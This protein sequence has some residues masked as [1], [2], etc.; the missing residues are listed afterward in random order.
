[1]RLLR[2]NSR[3]AT[4]LAF[5][6]I[7]AVFGITAASAQISVTS[8]LPN[9][10]TQG[11]TNLNVTVGGKGFKSGAKAQW[12]VSGTTN[13]GG[14]TVNSTAFVNANT[15]TANITV[16]GT[17]TIG[18]FDIQVTNTD[19]RTGKGS[20]LFAV[21][22][23]VTCADIP[24]QVIVKPQTIGQG[25]ISGDG[26]VIYDNP[27]NPSDPF[28]GGTL[29]Q[30][31]VGG[32]YARFQLCNGSNDFIFNMYTTSPVRYLNFDFSVQLAAPDTTAGAV[33][34]TGQQY[35]QQSEQINEMANAALYR[36]GQFEDCS[37]FQLNALSSTVIGGNF[38]FHPKSLYNP[39]VLDCNGGTA[40][41]IAN[42]PIDTSPV[43]IQQVNAC[44]WT[45]APM[46]DSTG[47]WQRV[48][49]AET[50]KIKGTNTS[51]AG[52]Q[53]Q[54]PFGYE[55]QKLNCTP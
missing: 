1:M 39:I 35:H 16:S 42:T 52:G 8:S 6:T 17:A 34:L 24:M 26:V 27:N 55:I 53:Y 25:G 22:S 51:V 12:F 31:G 43:L 37:G 18:G 9:N 49:I 41:D 15:L 36:N 44:T 54:M 38:W 14:V 19:G 50:V 3:P 28:N 13:P 47:V 5:L 11:T 30:D 10:A 46:L 23:K 40:Q 45:V 33:N 4:I 7:L 32:V 29:Y 48:G 20:E 21:R 2:A